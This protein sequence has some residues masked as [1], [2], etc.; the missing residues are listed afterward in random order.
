LHAFKTSRA[1]TPRRSP[2]VRPNVRVVADDSINFGR[3]DGRTQDTIVGGT[4]PRARPGGLGPWSFPALPAAD[5]AHEECVHG[6][7]GVSGVRFGLGC[8]DPNGGLDESS[9]ARARGLMMLGMTPPRRGREAAILSLL[10]DRRDPL[11]RAYA[12][13]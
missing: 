11:S 7:V 3:S 13:N 5:T 4:G 9:R 12:E 6:E 1:G 2:S 8:N 10:D